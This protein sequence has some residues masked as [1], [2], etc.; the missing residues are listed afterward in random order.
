MLL[1]PLLATLPPPA[2]I[3]AT[4]DRAGHRMEALAA[5]DRPGRVTDSVARGRHCTAD[6]A[7]CVELSEAPDSHDWRLELFEAAATEPRRILLPEHGS[8]TGWYALWPHLVRE[9]DGSVILGVNQQLSTGYAGGGASVSRL[10]LYRAE[11]GAAP[12]ELIDLPIGGATTIRACFS[13]ADR[14]ARADACADRYELA[15]EL[16]LDPA[17]ESE[18]PRFVLTT[19]ARTY[20]GHVSR[21][22]DS[23]DRGPLRREDLVWWN[24]PLCS[25]RRTLSFDPAVGRYAPDT[26]LPGCSDYL[27]IGA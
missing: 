20:P 1:A 27:D 15:G 23:R 22:E 14:R 7:L 2:A 12:A 19:T 11:P 4:T 8:G 17:N 6:G 13:Q 21:N 25:Y 5:A 16:A 9:R 3:E 26:P 10:L 18:R 24:D